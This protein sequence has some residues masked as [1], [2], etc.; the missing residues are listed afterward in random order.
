MSEE[1]KGPERRFK[2]YDGY[3]EYPGR[4]CGLVSICPTVDAILTDNPEMA[5][6]IRIV[7]IKPDFMR[8]F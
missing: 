3:T 5:V 6:A 4:D 7:K 8:V 2:G 1:V